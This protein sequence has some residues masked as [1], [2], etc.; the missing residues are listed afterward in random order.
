MSLSVL[1]LVLSYGYGTV[2]KQ[3]NMP[4]FVEQY[5]WI[6]IGTFVVHIFIGILMVLDHEERHRWHDF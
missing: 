6:M 2:E 1:F 4:E 3:V 5:R